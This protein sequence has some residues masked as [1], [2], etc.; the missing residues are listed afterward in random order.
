MS[1]PELSI[2]IINYK[3]PNLTSNCI[4]SIRKNTKGLNYEIIV[5]DNNSEDESKEF[6]TSNNANVKWIQSNQNSGT[7][8]GYNLGVKNANSDYV[9]ILN[10]DT[11]IRD[12]A[13]TNTLR[14][15]QEKE[16]HGKVGLTSCKIKGFDNEIQFTSNPNF[17]SIKKYLV[18]NPIMYK[19]GFRQPV[20][21][22]FEEK[23]ELHNKNH[24]TA[25]IG[26]AFGIINKRI[27]TE[28]NIWFDEDI[29]MY[30]DEVEWCYRLNKLGYKHYFT[31][32]YTIFHENSGSSVTSEWRYGQIFLS[33][34]L[35]FYKVFG[36][37]KFKL[38]VKSM[39]A[40]L[41]S[42]KDDECLIEKDVFDRYVQR[43]LD[44]YQPKVSSGSTFLKYELK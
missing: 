9:L 14:Y 26:I 20:G 38:M 28:E 8:R 13:I 15:H 11:I 34:I 1:K 19:I 2:V 31:S 18:Y 40:W 5:I 37:I 33:E 25:W 36:K 24:E 17:P 3:T 29:F 4:T 39:R 12:N 10:S 16:K 27:F 41:K 22:S 44:D 42:T 21:L 7:S 35:Y 32:D 43:I 6:I 23:L 30:S